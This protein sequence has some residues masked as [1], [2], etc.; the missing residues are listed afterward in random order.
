MNFFI[1]PLTTRTRPRPLSK[2]MPD[3]SITL[4]L[5]L[6]YKRRE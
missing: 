1:F 2:V 5:T 4:T 6:A 3:Y